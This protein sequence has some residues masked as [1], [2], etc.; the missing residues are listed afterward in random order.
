M[1]E[2]GAPLG[3]NNTR[4]GKAWTQALKRALAHYSNDSVDAG[5]D[6]LAKKMVKAAA[7]GDQEAYALI[8]RI[9]DRLEGKPAQ[10]I[11][12]DDE[13]PPV[14][15]TGVISLVKPKGEGGGE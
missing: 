7:E 14:Q 12:G 8:E 5:L 9:G 11:A 2:R 3:N 1:A 4:K 13:L 10:V 15:M 6:I